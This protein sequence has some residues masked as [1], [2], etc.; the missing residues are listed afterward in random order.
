MD[1]G[2]RQSDRSAAGGTTLIGATASASRSRATLNN[3]G[4]AGLLLLGAALPFELTQRPLLRTRLSHAH[5]P[6]A[7]RIRAGA[8]GPADAPPG[9]RAFAQYTAGRVLRS[10]ASTGRLGRPGPLLLHGGRNRSCRRR[11]AGMVAEGRLASRTMPAQSPL[12]PRCRRPACGPQVDI[13]SGSGRA[14]LAGYSAV[15]RR[16]G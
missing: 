5:Q 8:A 7:A 16:T 2:A 6:Q 14:T 12:K 4:Y 1:S 9:R 11:V 10:G 15:A 3:A 13:R